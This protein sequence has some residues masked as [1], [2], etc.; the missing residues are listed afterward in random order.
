MLLGGLSGPP[1]L[2]QGASRAINAENPTGAKGKGAVSSSVL[3]KGRKG[4]PCLKDIKSGETVT[5]ADVEGAGVITHIWMT[6][7]GIKVSPIRNMVSCR[8]ARK[9]GQGK[10][11]S[12]DDHV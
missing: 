10:Y 8:R 9:G 12:G 5:L 11:S 1:F 6:V 7:I 2:T 3:G 4:S